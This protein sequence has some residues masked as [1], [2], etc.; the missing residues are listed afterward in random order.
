MCRSIDA[1]Q[2]GLS[3]ATNVLYLDDCV[4]GREEAKNRQRLDDKW[5]IIS[6]DI[7]G[8]AI[9][10]TPIVATGTRYSLYDPIGHLR[11]SAKRRLGVESH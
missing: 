5:E 1:R 7:L 8:R 4:E 9:E 6:G 11:G 2:V 3:E 10:G